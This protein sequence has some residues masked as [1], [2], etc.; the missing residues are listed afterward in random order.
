MPSNGKQCDGTRRDGRACAGQ[1]LPG[2]THC[3]AHAPDLA[4]ARQAA[5]ERGGR[6]RA[7]VV[8]LQR[9]MPPRLVPIFDQLEQALAEVHAGTLE[10][11]QAVAMAALARAMC[12][13]LQIG[14]L[15]ERVRELEGRRQA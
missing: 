9:L 3:W 13:V 12:A 8:R 10:P 5:Y 4:A 11:R 6:N 15:E 7:H 14:E 2:R 1:A